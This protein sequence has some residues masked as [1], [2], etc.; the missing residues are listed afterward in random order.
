MEVVLLITYIANNRRLAR[1]DGMEQFGQL[2]GTLA[3]PL[4]FAG[5]GYY[6]TYIG[7][8]VCMIGT[9]AYLVFFVKEPMNREEEEG[10]EDNGT[11]ISTSR[12]LKF[13]HTS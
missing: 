4:L 3:S 6:G 7:K 12:M 8:T 11:G 13:Q 9:L 2:V 5:L 10:K 1:F